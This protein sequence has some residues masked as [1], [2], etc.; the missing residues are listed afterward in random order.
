MLYHLIDD[1]LRRPLALSLIST[2][3]YFY[4][5]SSF[6]VRCV[7]DVLPHAPIGTYAQG[8]P[9]DARRHP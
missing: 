9:Q 5:T 7:I 3:V 2:L 1:F 6:C 4:S 8:E